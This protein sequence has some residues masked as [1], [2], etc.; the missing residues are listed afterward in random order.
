MSNQSARIRAAPRDTFEA[1]SGLKFR[2]ILRQR[3]EADEDVV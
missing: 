2:R 1:L 3:T